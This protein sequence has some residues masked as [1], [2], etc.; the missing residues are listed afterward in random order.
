MGLSKKCSDVY[1]IRDDPTSEFSL[2]DSIGKVVIYS[3]WG[4]MGILTITE[5]I[6]D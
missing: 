1:I 2:E 5:V 3:S 6:I 4:R